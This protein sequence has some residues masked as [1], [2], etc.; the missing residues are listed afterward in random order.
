M[1]QLGQTI[2]RVSTSSK[3]PLA[4][5]LERANR[6]WE[7]LSLRLLKPMPKPKR[8]VHLG[9]FGGVQIYQK[10]RRT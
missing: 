4:Q 8:W 3:A 6:L 9:W 5:T 1:S 7:Q 10:G 2:Q